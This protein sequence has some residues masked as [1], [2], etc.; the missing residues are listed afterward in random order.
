M[1]WDRQQFDTPVAMAWPS[2]PGIRYERVFDLGELAVIESALPCIQKYRIHAE[3]TR[4]KA[5]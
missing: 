5:G 1:S 4:I 3:F 2:G